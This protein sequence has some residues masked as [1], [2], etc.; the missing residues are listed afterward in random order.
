VISF[1]G[2][3]NK[4]LR[5]EAQ[6]GRRAPMRWFYPLAFL[7]LLMPGA[8]KADPWAI[9]GTLLLPDAV[10]NDGTVVIV[11]DK[12]DQVGTGVP[13][14]TGV[15]PVDVGGFVLPGLIDLHNHLTWNLFPRW[16]AG[17]LFH[18]R[19]EWQEK[20]EYDRAMKSPEGRLLDRQFGCE[21]DLYAE[22]KALAGGATSTLGSLTPKNPGDLGCLGGLTR[23]LDFKSGIPFVP[24]TSSDCKNPEN[25]ADRAEYAKAIAPD[26]S[27]VT[28]NVVFPLETG[29]ERIDYLR[30]ELR[31][32]TLRSLVV[33]LAEGMPGDPT[34]RREFAM[35]RSR[36][37]VTA[38]VGVIHGSAVRPEEFAEMKLKGAGLIW[39]PR[40]NDELYGA[41]TNIGAAIQAGVTIAIAPD[42]SPTGSSGPLQEMNY[43]AAR[44]PAVTHNQLVDMA[45]VNAAQVA[46]LDG[47]IGQLKPGLFADLVVISNNSGSPK[48]KTPYESVVKATAADVQLVVVGG[49]P[50]Y[51]DRDLMTRLL[52]GKPL[53]DLTVC[54]AQKVVDLSS[55]GAAS[56]HENWAQLTQRLKAEL[57]RYGIELPAFECD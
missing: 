18:N 13:L 12:I 50:L 40:S 34:A 55:S 37:L 3:G 28:V 35:L 43:A 20:A 25:G 54:G 2:R 31:K 9:R 15:Q 39:S 56:I 24:D 30:C 5:A 44:F 33:H 1:G 48:D 11:G 7:F 10:I 17:Q 21:A 27:D 45:T 16:R 38:G 57:A 22:V 8:A 26:V 49:A 36:G 41:T 19:Y 47:F 14:P 46:R 29:H 52:P 53:D 51:G 23:N 6:D 4:K 42:W 32:G